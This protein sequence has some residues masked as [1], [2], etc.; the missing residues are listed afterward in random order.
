[1]PESD[2]E[3]LL[4]A[5]KEAGE[6]A[7]GFW[8]KDPKTWDKGVDDPVTEADLAVDTHLRDTLTAARPGYGW[9]SEETPDRT[10]RLSKE[11][12]FVVDPID[13]TRAFI[14]GQET[15]AHSIAIVTAGAATQGVVYLP[16]RKKLFAA[17][18]G[19]GAT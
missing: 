8:R 11:K 13:G 19:Q 1:M 12:V 5:A 4:R 18:K 7:Q 9:L 3:L 16:V 17:S 14:D 15:W 10:D 2:L 6:I